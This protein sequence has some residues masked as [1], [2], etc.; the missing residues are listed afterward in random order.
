MDIDKEPLKWNKLNE[1][2]S[3]LLLDLGIVNV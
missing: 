2:N 3:S 1:I